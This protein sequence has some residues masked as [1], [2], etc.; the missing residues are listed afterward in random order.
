MSETE[1]YEQSDDHSSSTEVEEQRRPRKGG[2][3]G[4][5]KREE[6]TSLVELQACPMA[7]TCFQYM[8]C[9]DFCERISRIQHHRE[10]ARLFVLHLHDGHVTLAGVNFTLTPEVIS[11]ATGIPNVGEV[12]PKRRLLDFVHF[13]PYVR[14]PFV[15][16]LTGVFP[17][18]FLRSEYAPIMRLIMH[19]FTCEGRFSQVYSYHIRLLMHFTRVR[20]MNI[21]VFLFHN[22][23]RMVPMLQK[24][25][26]AQQYRSLC[27]YGLIQLIVSHQLTQQ[28][29]S[30]EEFISRE[31][32]TVPPQ[33]HHEVIHEEGGPSQQPDAP[34]T[35]HVSS[36]PLVTYQ[37]GPRALFAAA[38]RVLSPQQVEGVS[39]SSSTQRVL[40]PH[41]VEGASLSSPAQVL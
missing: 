18:R 34:V 25:T 32:F 28:G 33:P 6:P 20:M 15:R 13:E 31:F 24:K 10:L 9:Y 4:H 3:G 17:F 41:Q 27:H 22:I 39:P 35:R 29:I 19:Y 23:Q 16:L 12:W 2:K 36:T 5:H 11:Q 21:P 37:K 7:V 1:T 14:P 30:W 8:S 38:R 26:P 40:S